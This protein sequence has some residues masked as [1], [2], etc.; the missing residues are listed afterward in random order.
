MFLTPGSLKAKRIPSTRVIF[1]LA[2]K[3]AELS[4][5]HLVSSSESRSAAMSINVLPPAG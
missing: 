5:Y 4:T 3:G 1:P 2:H